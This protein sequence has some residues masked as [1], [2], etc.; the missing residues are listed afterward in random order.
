MEN[1]KWIHNP[2]KSL[3]GMEKGLDHFSE[4]EMKKAITFHSSMPNYETTP[5]H[6]LDS[7]SEHL[8]VGSIYVKDESK[9]FGL[10]AF[11][12]LGGSYAI[13]SY[14]AKE[15][16]LDLK[17]TSFQA[18]I[19][20]VSSLPKVTFSTVTAGNHGKG[21]AWAAQLF[22]QD[23]KVY[24]PKG[25]SESRLNAIKEFGA[26]SYLSDVN[27]DDTVLQ[28]AELA[29]ENNWVLFQDTAWEGYETIPLYIIQGYMTIMAEI[30]EQ[31]KTA[32]LNNVT[33]I[34]LQA[35]VGSFAASIAAAFHHLTA[36]AN[37]S[38]K[39]IIVE[40]MEAECLY[41]SAKDAS[42]D[43]QRVYG[44]LD[45]MMA[46]LACGEPNPVA[47]DILKSISDYFLSTDD[48]ISAK[49]MQVL[50]KPLGGDA[51]VISGE[52]GAVTLGALYEILANDQNGTLKE[53]L[54]LDESS[55]ILV[56]STEGDTDP[57]NYQKVINETP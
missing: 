38:P 45:T 24:M 29:A 55:N 23:A 18:L 5:L 22:N 42:G 10:N 14:F 20:S 47:W 35:G 25:S 12:G 15:L 16:S 48:T 32:T 50:G 2:Y 31:L 9:R 13:A 4:S 53:E 19:E 44:D 7:L 57:E 54:G 21:V 52:S 30:A 34:F 41:Q 46:G 51:K 56:I 33:H 11:K 43:P 36:N 40:P 39:I 49:G 6:R 8:G 28:V 27:Y 3:D 17:T 1:I 37:K 26:E